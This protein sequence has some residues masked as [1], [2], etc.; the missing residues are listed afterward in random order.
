MRLVFFSYYITYHSLFIFACILNIISTNASK[1]V[2]SIATRFERKAVDLVG[3]ELTHRN[4]G[5]D[6]A[7]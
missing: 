1:V 7:H 6:S 5:N 3:M 2:I 4:T